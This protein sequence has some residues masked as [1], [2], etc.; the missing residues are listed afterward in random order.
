MN[1]QKSKQV[2]IEQRTVTKRK[3]PAVDESKRA[4]VEMV[5]FSTKRTRK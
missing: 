5:K 2:I 1:Q 3:Q 4:A